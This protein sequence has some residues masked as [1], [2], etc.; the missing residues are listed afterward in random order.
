MANASSHR[1]LLLMNFSVYSLFKFVLIS[2]LNDKFQI[3]IINES[4]KKLKTSYLFE[5]W[6]RWIQN[7]LVTGFNMFRRFNYSVS[8]SIAVAAIVVN[9]TIF[10]KFQH[11]R[12][13]Y[14]GQNSP[15]GRCTATKLINW[16]IKYWI[17]FSKTKGTK[18]KGSAS[19][20]SK[21]HPK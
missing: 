15:R 5:K 6:R 3:K 2:L 8:R 10:I 13:E 12:A 20:M 7:N 4:S 16:F 14:K 11:K 9:E 17:L 18:T 1:Y 21:P 19:N